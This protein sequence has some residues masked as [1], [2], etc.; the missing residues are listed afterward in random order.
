MQIGLA[1]MTSDVVVVVV[2]FF[3]A[4]PCKSVTRNKMN[5]MANFV[6]IFIDQIF[7]VSDIL[8]RLCK[9]SGIFPAWKITNYVLPFNFY[10]NKAQ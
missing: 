6:D 10:P 4:Q 7:V 2:V 1:V 3:V 9:N 5:T 8:S